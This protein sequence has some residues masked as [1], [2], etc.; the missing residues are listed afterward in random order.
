MKLIITNSN[1]P[2]LISSHPEIIK[3]L[4]NYFV[5]NFVL[6]LICL[7]SGFFLLFHSFL[8]FIALVAF[9]TYFFYKSYKFR[10]AYT[11]ACNIYQ[12]QTNKTPVRS[13]YVKNVIP[14]NITQ[15]T[16]P[17]KT[18]YIEYNQI[19]RHE[20]SCNNLNC[21]EYIFSGKYVETNR[22]RTKKHIIVFPDQNVKEEIIRLG[23]TDPIEYSL[24]ESC[25]AS[26]K[27]LAYLKDLTK[28]SVPSHLSLK[29]ASALISRIT[30]HDHIPNPQLLEFATQMHIEVSFF[31]GKKRLYNTIFSNLPTIDRIAFFVFCV[32][33]SLSKDFS[34]SNLNHSVH[35]RLFYEFAD[36]RKD[37][38]S[39]LRSMNNYTGA[40]LRFFGTKTINGL[41]ITGGSKNT[42]AYTQAKQFLNEK[43]LS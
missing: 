27:Q 3:T 30:E 2:E 32:Y 11:D 29:D 43:I 33:R 34:V 8:G 9:A 35:K 36:L 4:H 42:I 12:Q 10:L 22:I 7:V 5:R 39:F 26:E 23:Y 21:D 17:S 20:T 1:L 15:Q 18:Q 37:D 41:I 28:N 25:P 13:Y 16:L 38:T 40:E 14:F 6:G 31:I 24:E 19:Y